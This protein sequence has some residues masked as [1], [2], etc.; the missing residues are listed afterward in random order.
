[1]VAYDRSWLFRL[2]ASPLSTIVRGLCLLC[3]FA[4]PYLV[5][6]DGSTWTMPYNS[7]NVSSSSPLFQLIQTGTGRVGWLQISNSSNMTEALYVAT[8][9]SGTAIYGY[10]SGTGKA[11]Y[12]VINNSSNSS[13]ALHAL[14]TGTGGAGYFQIN[15]SA[16]SASAL[17]AYTSGTGYAGWFEIGNASSSRAAIYANTIGTGD[18]IYG[19]SLRRNGVYGVSLNENQS[20]VFGQNLNGGYGVRG[21]TNTPQYRNTAG[22]WGHN[23]GYGDGVKGTSV[24]GTGVVGDG[25]SAG[26]RGFGTTGVIGQSSVTDGNGVSGVASIGTGA[27]GV[28]GETQQGIGVYGY[29]LATSGVNY[30]VYGQTNSTSGY[31]GYFQGK[32]HVNGT[33][34]KSAG[35]FKIDHPLDPANK[36]LSHSFVE[37]PDMKNVYD[38]VVILDAHGEAWVE[39]PDWFEAL[40]KEF[41]YQLTPIGAPAP[42]LYIAQEI[43]HNRF[44]IA[45]GVPGQKVSWQVTG[46]RQDPY[47][48]RYRIPVEEDK[49]DQERG[50]YLNPELYGQPEEMRIGYM[51]KKTL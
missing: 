17:R 13:L 50:R 38:G 22:I 11:G 31:A 34:S 24:R 9:G 10:S 49:P 45:G 29:A 1:M 23:D 44:K 36:Y 47:A 43:R 16:N 26:V 20:G 48:D 3:S 18:G 32:V 6:A 46:I 4:L 2:I 5:L 25:N 30:G 19:R 27:Y 33:L 41:R 35:S 15:N 40:N 7:G 21:H 28:Y 37:S 51:R 8:N 42:N 12:F 39:L 14:T